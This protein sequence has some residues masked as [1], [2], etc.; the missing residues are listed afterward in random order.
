[1]VREKGLLE[2]SPDSSLLRSA[3]W[4]NPYK[5]DGLFLSA[6]YSFLIYQAPD[7]HLVHSGHLNSAKSSMSKPCC[8][9]HRK[10]LFVDARNGDK[11]SIQSFINSHRCRNKSAAWRKYRA[12]KPGAPIG[13]A[14]KVQHTAS[15]ETHQITPST[16]LPTYVSIDFCSLCEYIEDSRELNKPQRPSTQFSR[17]NLADSM[18]YKLSKSPLMMLERG[19]IHVDPF[20]HLPIA[21]DRQAQELYRFSTTFLSQDCFYSRYHSPAMVRENGMASHV[22]SEMML[23]QTLAG[24]STFLDY[25]NPTGWEASTRTMQWESAAMQC[26]GRRIENPSTR[27]GDECLSG[28][29]S[30]LL[31]DALTPE[32]PERHIHSRAMAQLLVHRESCGAVYT[33][34][35]HLS[36]TMSILTLKSQT[37]YLDHVQP[38]RPGIEEVRVW[39][40]NVVS[41]VEN[42]RAMS[43][44][45]HH[46]QCTFSRAQILGNAALLQLLQTLT[47]YPFN[48]FESSNQSFVLCYLALSVTRHEDL[49][50]CTTFLQSFSAR[51]EQL[52]TDSALLRNAVWICVKGVGNHYNYKRDAIR[53]ARVFHRL[54]ESKQSEV[55]NFLAGVCTPHISLSEKDCNTIGRQALVGLPCNPVGS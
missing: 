41:F 48:E 23:C 33:D 30:L 35:D 47:K 4:V 49:L 42:L 3:L 36:S 25:M 24:A 15:S 18:G 5:R 7:V 29:L 2:T 55:K 46:A 28:I 6:I 53:M 16:L 26:L 34:S 1:M 22:S 13:W 43:A 8:E 17:T 9:Y 38:G 19:L 40:K 45:I 21:L 44:W 14:R 54:T 51:L 37:A 31:R 20:S 52:G 39:T 12:A 50:S 11:D 32:S 10:L 27:Y